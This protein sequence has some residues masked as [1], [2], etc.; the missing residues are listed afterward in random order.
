MTSS[1]DVRLESIKDTKVDVVNGKLRKPHRGS[2]I[3]VS[4]PGSNSAGAGSMLK[5]LRSA[6]ILGKAHVRAESSPSDDRG[7]KRVVSNPDTDVIKK[8]LSDV[9]S[10]SDT[11]GLSLINDGSFIKVPLCPVNDFVMNLDFGCPVAFS[12]GPKD[13]VEPASIGVVGNASHVHTSPLDSTTFAKTGMDFEF[14]KVDRS[15]GILKKPLSPLLNVQFGSNIPVNPFVKSSV[16][17]GSYEN[18]NSNKGAEE[19]ALKMEYMPNAV[20]KLKNGGRLISFSVEEVIKGGAECALQLY[21]YFVGT[22]MDYRVVRANLMKMWRIHGI[23]G[24]TKTNSVLNIWEAGIWLEKVEPSTI[25]IWVCVYNIPMELCNSSSIG[26]IMS[27]IEVNDV[28]DLLNVLEIAYPPIGSSPAKIGRLEVKYQWKPPLCTH[29]KTFGHSTVACKVRLQTEEEKAAAILKETLK[30]NDV[31]KDS[32]VSDLN[33]NGFVMVG[34]KN[35]PIVNKHM[36][37]QVNSQVKQ[38][39]NGQNRGGFNFGRQFGSGFYNQNKQG[40]QFWQAGKGSNKQGSGVVKE[41]AQQQEVLLK[42]NGDAKN[43]SKNVN[44]SDVEGQKKSLRHLSQDL[45]FKPKVLVRGSGLGSDL[46]KNQEDVVPFSNPFD[47]LFDDAMNAEFESS[48]WPK[49]HSEIDELMETGVYPSKEVRAVWSLCQAEYFYNNCHKYHIDPS[50]E[51]EED[52]VI[53]EVDGI[54][55]DMKPEYEVIN[56]GV[57]ENKSANIPNVFNETHI[58]KK[59]LAKI[60]RRVLGNWDWVSNNSSC[61]GG[62]RIIVGWDPNIVNVKVLDQSAQVMHCFIEPVNGDSGFFCSFVYAFVHTVDR[63]SLWKALKIHKGLVR[64]RPW[65]ILGDFNACL[66][67]SER[68]SGCSKFTSAMADFRDCV[69]D[70]DV[71]DIAMTGLNFTWNKK[72]GKDGGLLKKLDRVLGNIHFMSSFPLSY[73]YL[74]P[75][76]LSDHTHAVLVMPKI[77]NA[78]PKPFKFHNY[79]TAKD[80]FIPVVR[81]VWNVKIDGFSMFLL[82]SKLKLLKKPLRKLNFEVEEL[83][84]L[85]AY[86]AALKDEE[87]FLRQKAKVKWLEAEYEGVP[88]DA[89][90]VGDQFVNHFKNVLGQSSYV[91]PFTD[92]NSLFVKKLPVLEA[93]NLVRNEE[94]K[95]ALFDIDRNKASGLDGFSSQFFKVSWSVVG[96]DVCKAVRDFFSNGKLLKEINPTVISLVP[97]VAS[98]SKV[99]DYRPIACCNVVYKIISKV[100]CN[101]LKGVLGFLVD[102]NQSAFIPTRQISDN[103]MLSQELMRNYHRNRGPA[104]CAFK[105]DI[106]KAYDS[107]EWVFLSSILKHFGFPELLVKWIMSCVT[108]TSFTVNVNGDHT[109]FFKGMRGLRQGDPLSPYLFTLVMEVF[110]LVLRREIDK[111]PSFRYH[112]QCKELKLTHLC[113]ADDLLLFCNGDSR[114]VAV[115]KNA[116]TEFGGLS[117]LLPNLTKSTIFF[118]NVREV[119]RLRIL[120]IMPFRVGSLP[121]RYLGVPLISKRLYVKDCQLLIDKARKRLLDWKNK[122]LSFAGRLQLIMS[123]VSSMQVYWASVFIL[124][125][126]IANDIERL[127]RDFLWNY[128]VFKRGKASVNWSSVCKPKVEGGLGIKSL[129]SWNKA[130]MSKHIW[131]IITQKESLWVRWINTYRLKGRSFWDVPDKDGACWA[132]KKLLR[133]RCVFRS[134]IYYK[135]GDGKNTSLWFDNWHT[136]CPLSNF[137]SKRNNFASGLSLGCKVADVIK[138]GAWDWP[139]IISNSFDALTVIPPPILV[140]DK[141]NVVKWKSLNGRL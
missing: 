131:N 90:N 88:F 8:V 109:G 20:S 40:N 87:L 63:R 117:G 49:L 36:P 99:S 123:V 61:T 78:K 98:P 138:K 111:S 21:G 4:T 42:K 23:V 118:G 54:A 48:I 43:N 44:S 126:A 73:A 94:I 106:E 6:K 93:L 58:Q 128:G 37:S 125:S 57:L 83:R 103:I 139:S 100:I 15:I 130:L 140:Q 134:H 95:S 17:N 127:M 105:I 10:D 26:K 59:N 53:S 85:K 122:S 31:P 71:E 114:S 64:N 45:N 136:I 108:S 29:C 137:I 86:K 24:I 75:Y 66:D 84:V 28:D 112:W 89:N 32:V 113:F 104:K 34:K 115:L 70:I 60:C 68:S 129:D 116:L 39:F 47:E 30:V 74:L 18:W 102:E 120:N 25:P 69:A 11:N 12:S 80:D 38:G 46:K 35:K 41:K 135:I 52:D 55:F 77:G 81:R 76:M 67:P 14:G 141:P 132:W 33:N 119:S 97:K 124:P 101:R 56:A 16:G 7:G 9:R 91:L 110:N 1:D 62:T 121:V 22:S 5:R 3:K 133:Y 79:L 96:D 13:C 72:P 51:D 27:G 2:K 82:V 92:L 50:Y 107:V 19:L 65:T